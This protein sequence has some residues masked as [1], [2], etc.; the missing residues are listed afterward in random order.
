[1]SGEE[2]ERERREGGREGGGEGGWKGGRSEGGRRGGEQKNEERGAIARKRRAL[3]SIVN[4]ISIRSF[5]P[6]LPCFV[7]PWS[8]ARWHAVD[9]RTSSTAVESRRR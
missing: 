7:H 2:R 1:M 5:R 6:L 9:Q 8:P 3:F 4:G